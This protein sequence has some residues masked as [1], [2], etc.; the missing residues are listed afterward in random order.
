MMIIKYG[1]RALYGYNLSV[2][3][4]TNATD[5]NDKCNMVSRP[6]STTTYISSHDATHTHGR[7][8][9]LNE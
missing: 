2:I 3:I 9:A 1:L 4:N 5:M 7:A 8:I 6:V